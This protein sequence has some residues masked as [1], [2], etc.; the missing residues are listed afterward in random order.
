[1]IGYVD[2]QTPI[3]NAAN[4]FF[5]NSRRSYFFSI[6]ERCVVA[7]SQIIQQG[8]AA[9]C[10]EKEDVTI[11][12]GFWND[13]H[14]STQYYQLIAAAVLEKFTPSRVPRPKRF[15]VLDKFFSKLSL[16]QLEVLF[17]RLYRR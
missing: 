9:S 15:G 16:Q 11:P 17:T 4:S 6:G 10:F 1:M 13:A 3:G 8:E 2:I 14:L 5:I 12:I 7:T